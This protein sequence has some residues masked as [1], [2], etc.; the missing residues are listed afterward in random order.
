VLVIFKLASVFSRVVRYYIISFYRPDDIPHLKQKWAVKAMQDLGYDIKVSGPAPQANGKA[1][2]LVGN[3]ISYLDIVLLMALHPEVV[4]VAKKEVS[5]FPI[6]GQAAKRIG[7]LF[8]DREHKGDREKVRRQLADRLKETQSQVVVFPSG[9]TT[10]DENKIW[11]KGAFE[12]AH[13]HSIPVKAFKIN[14]NPLRESAYIDDDNL[15]KQMYNVSK[16]KKKSAELIWLSDYQ[17]TS[18]TE[19]AERI[20]LA[21]MKK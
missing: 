5:G 1:L 6:I 9:T 7:T 14:Y 18:P 19:D 15:L 10:L 4:F 12:I 8:V 20:R 3:H 11:K 17:I 16:L 2:I 13:E 21:V